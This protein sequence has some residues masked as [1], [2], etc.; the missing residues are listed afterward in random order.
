MSH[1]SPATMVADADAATEFRTLGVSD[2]VCAVLEEQGILNPFP[3]QSAVI[4][5]ALRGGDV[6]AKSPT[7]SGKT[8]AFA[9]PIVERIDQLERRHRRARA[10][11]HPRALLAGHRD[12]GARRRAPRESA[13]SPSTAA[14]R[15]AS[16]PTTPA[17]RTCSSRR[18]AGSRISSIAS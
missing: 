17:T 3:V 14:C 8:L 16:R 18:R 13:R 4:P 15:S 11:A 1:H 10:R 6:L 5:E 9:I 12:D 2:A 7:G